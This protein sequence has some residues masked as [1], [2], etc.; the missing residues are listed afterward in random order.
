MTL[1]HLNGSNGSTDIVDVM[2]NAWTANGGAKLTTADSKFG[3]S[4]LALDGDGDYVSMAGSLAFYFEAN[5]F[6][7]EAW[8]KPT[9]TGREM[10]MVDHYLS[11][12]AA[13]QV[14]VT[15]A[16]LLSFYGWNGSTTN[17]I[18]SG[19]SSLWGAWHHIAVS[20]RNG[21]IRLFVDGVLENSVPHTASFTAQ[22]S[23]FALGAQVSARNAAYDYAGLM[24][25]VRVIRGTGLYLDS[26]TPPA[27][28]FADE[29]RPSVLEASLPLPAG[30]AAASFSGVVPVTKQRLYRNFNIL[31]AEARLIGT[32]KEK[33]LPANTPLRRRVRLIRER[34]GATVGQTWSDMTTGSYVFTNID[35]AEAYTVIAYDYQH[36]HRA[37]VADNLTVAGG[38][39][40]L[41]A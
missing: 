32:V 35:S 39:V 23:Y 25:E 29:T 5:D 22:P 2:R 13:W 15:S 38:G 9:N 1:L 16:G 8:M 18:V 34:D 21:V 14:L 24:D 27:A 31:G 17:Y 6:T 37:V 36:N 11:G 30:L 3:G 20:K 40:E 12:Q 4:C 10:V 41:V 19:T 26:F 33:H 7:I 28:P